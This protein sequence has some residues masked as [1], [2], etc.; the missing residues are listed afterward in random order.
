MNLIAKYIVTT[1]RPKIF[2]LLY[3]FYKTPNKQVGNHNKPE[4]LVNKIDCNSYALFHRNNKPIYLRLMISESL[5]NQPAL[6]TLLELCK[7]ST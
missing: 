6:S 7:L 4:D 1:I 2:Y 5:F 3:A